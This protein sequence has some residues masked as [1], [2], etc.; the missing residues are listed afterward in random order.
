MFN[1]DGKQGLKIDNKIQYVHTNIIVENW[2]IF[3]LIFLTAG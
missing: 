2:L 3:V 1:I